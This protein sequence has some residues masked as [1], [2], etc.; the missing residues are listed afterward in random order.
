MLTDKV[1]FKLKEF[2]NLCKAHK[3]KEL[4]AFGSVVNGNFT[5]ES[6]IDLLVEIDEPDPLE[7]GQL[8]LALWD[9]LENYFNRKVDLLT[10]NSLKNPYLK[11]SINSTRKLVYDGS[12][13]KILL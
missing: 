2:I 8:L 10:S 4:Y 7:R 3:V 6:D 9:Q 1:N 13:E 11:K 12:K 5:N